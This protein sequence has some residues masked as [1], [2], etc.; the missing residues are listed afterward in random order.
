MGVGE[1]N[2]CDL[3]SY[4]WNKHLKNLN[5]PFLSP[6]P[7]PHPLPLPIQFLYIPDVYLNKM[8]VLVL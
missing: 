4:M 1:Y 6:H 2:L 5:S 7:T 8:I 3:L